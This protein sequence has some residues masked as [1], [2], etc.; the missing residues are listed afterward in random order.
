MSIYAPPSPAL[1]D[2]LLHDLHAVPDAETG[3]AIS[4]QPDMRWVERKMGDSELSY[5]LPSRASGVNDMYLHLGFNAPEHLVRRARVRVVWAILRV[6]HPLLASTVTMHNYED[7]RFR[8]APPQSPEDVLLDADKNLEYRSASKDEL[9]DTYLNGERTLSNERLS[10]LIVSQGGSSSLPSPPL[11]PRQTTRTMEETSEPI[12]NHDMLICAAHF[13]GD[14]MALHQ[15]ANDFFRILGGEETQQELE[16]RL[17]EEWARHC[18][19]SPDKNVALP[20]AMEDNFT[21]ESSKFRLA[22][23]KIDFKTAQ[24]KT[25]GGQT[26]PRKFKQARHTVVPTVSYDADRTK[27]ILKRCKANGVSVSAALFAV[28]NL[29]WAR[30]GQGPRDLPTLMYSA[31]NLRPFFTV[32]PPHD[33]YWYLA[34]G[35]FNVVLPNI[36]PQSTELSSIFWH[37]ARVAKEQSTRAAKNPMV[38]S[39]CRLMAEERGQRAR[40]WAKEDDDRERGTFVPPPPAPP[41]APRAPSSALIGLS[42]LGNLDGIY[43]HASFPAVKLHSLTTGSRQRAG[44]MLMFGYT[45][46]GKLW[47]SLGYDANGFEKETVERFWEGVLEATDELL[48]R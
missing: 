33:S 1:S 6:R 28:C 10:Y 15:F 23:G 29:A 48:M 45:F 39:R 32:K 12:Y 24:D 25:I 13:L 4:G 36:V 3:K 27:T 7:V 37:R 47:I 16:L 5:F 41:A 9:I 42:L 19:P 43:K 20:S 22:V 26:F 14:G 30:I 40:V 35:Y 46:A 44:G 17:C 18:S 34:V 21:A 38:V 31:L 2:I 8:Y 11:T